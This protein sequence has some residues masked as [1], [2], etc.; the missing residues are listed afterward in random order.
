MPRANSLIVATHGR[1]LWILDHLEPIQEYAAAQA[2]A[3]GAHLFAVPNALE[4][5]TKDDRND[6][7]WGHQFF[8]GENPPNEAV[9]QFFLNSAVTDA[10]LKIT[11]TAGKD[12]RELVVPANR[13]QPGIQTVCWVLRVEPIAAAGGAAGGAGQFGGRGAGGGA[14]RGGAGAVAVLAPLDGPAS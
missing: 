8:V 13:S 5:K 9:I 4:W 6:E 10:K 3:G 11:D 7:F 12:V 2:A 14:G 1:A